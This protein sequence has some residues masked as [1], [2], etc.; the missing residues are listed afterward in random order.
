MEVVTDP[1]ILRAIEEE[2]KKKQYNIQDGSIVTDPKIINKINQEEEKKQSLKPEN[3]FFSKYISGEDRTEFKNFKE[4][5]EINIL[6]NQG[7]SDIGKKYIYC[8]SFKFNA[9]SR[10]TNRYD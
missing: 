7:K 9:I 2:D 3:S 8:D 1:N 6:K 5:G 10:C 4:I